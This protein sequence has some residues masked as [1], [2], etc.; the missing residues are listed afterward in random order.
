MHLGSDHLCASSNPHQS[1]GVSTLLL[2]AGGV[3]P[4]TRVPNSLPCSSP[5]GLSGEGLCLTNCIYHL[6]NALPVSPNLCLGWGE[7]RDD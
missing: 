7:E 2:S 5:G 1:S 3:S 6:G 4:P